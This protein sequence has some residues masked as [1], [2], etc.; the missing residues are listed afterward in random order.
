MSLPSR[1]APSVA[2][3]NLLLQPIAPN[4]ARAMPGCGAASAANGTRLILV[5]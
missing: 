3:N 4:V 1:A 5:E 2:Q